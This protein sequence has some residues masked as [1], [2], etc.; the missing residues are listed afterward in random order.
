MDIFYV[1][2]L[3]IAV[4]LLILILTYIGIKMAYNA[5]SS[6]Q[7]EFTAQYSSCPDYWNVDSNGLCVIPASTAKNY[8]SIDTNN[9]GSFGINSGKTA[10]DFSAACWSTSGS[11]V[12]SKKSWTTSRGISWDGISNYNGCT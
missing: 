5:T 7:N 9:L 6:G 10:V 3:S 11:S 1:I 2:V 12:C 4:C 8:G